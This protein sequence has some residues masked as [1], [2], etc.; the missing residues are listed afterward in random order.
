MCIY[1]FSD[2]YSDAQ[3]ALRNILSLNLSTLDSSCSFLSNYSN[4]EFY[5]FKGFNERY[6]FFNNK[7]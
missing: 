3:Q 4:N 6:F 1:K 7:M 5:N 2:L